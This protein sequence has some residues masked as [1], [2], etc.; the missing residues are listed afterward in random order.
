MILPADLESKQQTA[1][2]W[3]RTLRDQFCAAFEAIEDALTGPLSD[4]EPVVYSP[5]LRPGRS[6]FCVRYE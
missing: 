6:G 5:R 3:F 4:R 2:A 1:S